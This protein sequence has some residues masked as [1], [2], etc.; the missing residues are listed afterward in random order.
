[1]V[2]IDAHCH[3]EL[4]AVGQGLDALLERARTAGLVHAVV[5][6]QLQEDGTF[7]D[8]LRVAAQAPGFLSATMGIHPHDAARASLAHWAELEALCARLD[9][10]AVGEA[11]LDHYYDHS[12]R[13]VQ[14]Q[15]FRRQCQLAARLAKPLV[16]HVRDAHDECLRILREEEIRSGVI[17]CFTGGPREAEGYLAQGLLLSFSGILTYKK[18]E[19]LQEAARLCP[20]D[21]L[22]VETDT[23]YLAP[24]PFRGKKNEPGWVVETAK[25]LAE[26]KGVSVEQAALHAAHNTRRLFQLPV[27]LPPL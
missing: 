21:R 7:G 17:H 4:R 14:A 10:V 15:A 24:V 26:L 20:L 9:V 16:V 6:G 19:A 27:S 18:T 22:M 2:I 13:E 25:K 3:L 8:A 5:I 1:V 12:P 23:P 11:G